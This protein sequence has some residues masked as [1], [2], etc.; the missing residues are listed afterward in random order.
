MEIKAIEKH[1][2]N[3]EKQRKTGIKQEALDA[4]ERLKMEQNQ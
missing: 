1:Y 4:I 2:D 3:L